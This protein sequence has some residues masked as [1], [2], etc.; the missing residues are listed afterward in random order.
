MVVLFNHLFRYRLMSNNYNKKMV[1]IIRIIKI[2]MIN[3][4]IKLRILIKIEVVK[5]QKEVEKVVNLTLP[6]KVLS[7]RNIK[8]ILIKVKVKIRVKRNHRSL[9]NLSI[10]LTMI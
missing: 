3:Y 1:L 9:R 8:V 7:K 6:R 2:M 10:I 5:C 4:T